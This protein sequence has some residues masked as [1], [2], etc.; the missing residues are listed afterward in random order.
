VHPEKYFGEKQT[1]LGNSAFEN[2]YDK[3]LSNKCPHGTMEQPNIW[4]NLMRIGMPPPPISNEHTIGMLM[5]QFPWLLS[6][7]FIVNRR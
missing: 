3:V 1:I 5:G 6:I 2:S 7:H 4:N